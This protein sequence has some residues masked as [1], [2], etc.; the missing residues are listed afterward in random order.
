[1][2]QK[3]FIVCES[4][5]GDFTFS[6][7]MPLGASWDAALKAASEI[8]SGLQ[9]HVKKLQEEEKKKEAAPEVAAELVG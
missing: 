1:M 2:D 4:K 6:Y 5:Q 3:G 8:F 9:E 7:H